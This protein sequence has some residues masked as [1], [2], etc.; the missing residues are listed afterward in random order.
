MASFYEVRFP[1]DLAY[2]ARGGRE[3]KTFITEQENGFEQRNQVQSATR[4][5]WNISGGLLTKDTVGPLGI[6]NL[7]NF[8]NAMR[9]RLYGFRFKDF[10]DFKATQSTGLIGNGSGTG[11]QDYQ[12]RKKYT[13]GDAKYIA[14]IKKP[15]D[16]TVKLYCNGEEIAFNKYNIDYSKG[17]VNF[18]YMP[19]NCQVNAGSGFVT[20][21]TANINDFQR[22]DLLLFDN[23]GSSL[24]KYSVYKVASVVTNKQFTIEVNNPGQQACTVGRLYQPTDTLTAEYEFDYPVRFDNDIIEKGQDEAGFI[25]I[26]NISL[27]ELKL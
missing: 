11:Y 3:F 19:D 13:V 4:G 24:F 2:L 6:F 27:V 1:D 21:T 14:D 8:H 23:G 18:Y 17:I 26:D 15:V 25:S 9:G 20:V 12:L 7:I 22:G 5:R 10:Q 16:G